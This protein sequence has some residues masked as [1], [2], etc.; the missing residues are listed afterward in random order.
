MS[1]TDPYFVGESITYECND[2]YDADGADLTN[3]CV[4]NT[5]G[6]NPA[7]WSRMTGDLTGIC[8][9]GI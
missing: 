4:E 8:L 6:G 3:E 2:T 5:G 7:V 9:A 1:D